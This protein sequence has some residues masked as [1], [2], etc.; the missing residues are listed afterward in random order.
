MLARKVGLA[1]ILA[2]ASLGCVVMLH[3]AGLVIVI[4]AWSKGSSDSSTLRVVQPAT[5]KLNALLAQSRLVLNI[6]HYIQLGLPGFDGARS[7]RREG[8][9]EIE[10][11]AAR[12]ISCKAHGPVSWHGSCYDLASVDQLHR[13]DGC[14]FPRSGA[15][16]GQGEDKQRSPVGTQIV[17]LDLRGDDVSSFNNFGLLDLSFNQLAL[18]LHDLILSIHDD[19]LISHQSVLFPTYPPLKNGYQRE[20]RGKESNP[21]IG[22]RVLIALVGTLLSLLGRD[23]GDRLISD[24]RR[25]IGWLVVT[26]SFLLFVGPLFLVYVTGFRFSWHWWL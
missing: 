18:L 14:C 13:H 9:N 23:I 22:R 7:I 16:V 1:V 20:N 6:G 15:I 3:I 21:P 17:S 12:F 19:I 25:R 24:G 10:A 11:H 4:H 5:V 8:V 2:L 26:F